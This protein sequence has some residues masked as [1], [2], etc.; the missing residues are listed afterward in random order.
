MQN[1]RKMQTISESDHL[2][3]AITKNNSFRAIALSTRDLTEEARQRHNLSHTAT[4]AL[5]RVLACA[6]L[7][8]YTL[9]KTKGHLTLKFR[10]DGPLGT[11]I[12]DASNEGTIRGYISNPQVEVFDKKGYVDIDKAIGKTGYVHVIYETEVGL[13]HQGTVEI[14]TGEVASD[15]VNYLARSEQ[16]PSFVSCGVYLDPKS[17]KVLHAGAILIQ[18]LPDASEEDIKLVE[19]TVSKLDPYSILL[20]SRLNIE[21]IIKKAL[22]DFEVN[23]ISEFEGLCFYCGCSLKKFEDA[24]FTLGKE[25]IKKIIDTTGYA[26]GICHFCNNV[27]IIKKEQLEDYLN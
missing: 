7:L 8:C 3:K 20:R 13:P 24:I 21:E 12:V 22:S 4:V 9:K 15:V 11:I 5:G 23:I 19:E 14:V 26:E 6:F 1:N 16:I 17:G 27:Y 18:A 10:G 25:E 2:V